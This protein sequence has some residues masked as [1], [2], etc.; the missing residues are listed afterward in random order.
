MLKPPYFRRGL[1]RSQEPSISEEC[2]IVS[3][4]G[5]FERSG[6]SYELL[7]SREFQFLNAEALQP[8]VLRK[9]DPAKSLKSKLAAIFACAI[10]VS[11]PIAVRIAVWRWSSILTGGKWALIA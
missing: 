9:S 1:A 2:K 7:I 11:T 10:L 3:L 5:M 6:N 4:E 8:L